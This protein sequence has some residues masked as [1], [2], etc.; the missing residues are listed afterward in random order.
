[1]RLWAREFTKELMENQIL[2]DKSWMGKD[3]LE[4]LDNLKRRKR[5]R[6]PVAHIIGN[7]EKVMK[8]KMIPIAERT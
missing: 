6:N 2:P 8:L 1:M 5:M 7:M 4:T 3:L